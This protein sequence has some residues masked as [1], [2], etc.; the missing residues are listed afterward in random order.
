[1]NKFFFWERVKSIIVAIIML[2]AGAFLVYGGLGFEIP[3]IG[4]SGE[5]YWFL[6]IVGV[7]FLLYGAFAVWNS[8]WGV[9]EDV[10][11]NSRFSSEAEERNKSS[12]AIAESFQAN[13]KNKQTYTENK[14]NIPTEELQDLKKLYDEGILTENEFIE[15]KRELLKLQ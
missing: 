3:W 15:K 11:R 2:P 13:K 9:N 1:M 7:S 14:E 8:Y 12:R 5:R 6:V 4:D 10:E